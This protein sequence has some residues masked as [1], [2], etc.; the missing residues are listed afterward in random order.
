[1]QKA[2]LCALTCLLM[3]LPP[4][5]NAITGGGGYLY[6]TSFMLMGDHYTE[7]LSR[8]STDNI[9]GLES[10]QK[11]ICQQRYDGILN[12]GILDIRIAL[13][14][15]DW[16]TGG[17][18]HYSGRSFGL[19]PSMDIGAFEALRE[20][21]TSPCY[22]QLRFCG[23]RITPQNRSLLTKDVQIH[24]HRILARIEIQFASATEFY[25]ENT[26]GYREQ[27]RQRTRYL[28]N[29][30]SKALGEADAIFYFGHSRNGGGPDFAPPVFVGSTNKVDYAGY[31][32][33]QR[34]GFNR[35]LSSLS[36]SPRQA[37]IIGLMSCASRNHFLKRTRAVA[38]A[39]GVITSLDVLS[40]NEVYTAMI[41]GVDALLRGQCQKSFFQSLRMTAENQKYLTMDGMFE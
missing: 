28:E 11:R 38:P 37:P 34:P 12:D 26:G 1:M 23:F 10:H 7:L 31:Y 9:H 22:G 16:T 14:Y 41:G 25:S 40:V 27:Q 6:E 17:N 35:M 24:G 33:P 29:F 8:K 20:L 3:T 4:K 19:S 30:F 21:L 13:G 2:F 32:Q 15:F 36:S 39:S 5:G 18:V